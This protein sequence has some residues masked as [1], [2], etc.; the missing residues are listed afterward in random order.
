MKAMPQKLLKHPL[1]TDGDGLMHYFGEIARAVTIPIMVQDAP[2]MT[3]VA[4]PAPLLARMA[5]EIDRVTLANLTF[6]VGALG[7]C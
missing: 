1:K 2:L 6:A 3:Q 7:R 4:M 5:Q